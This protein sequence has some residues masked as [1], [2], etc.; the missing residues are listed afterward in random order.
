MTGRRGAA[1]SCPNDAELARLL[2]RVAGGDRAAFEALYVASAPKLF[3]LILRMSRTRPGAE[4]ILQEVFVKVWRGAHA[5]SPD[6]GAPMTW[7]ASIARNRTID[8]L[9]QRAPAAHGH[10]DEDE[11]WV[12]R[13]PDPLDLEDALMNAAD[14]RH[15]LARLDP[16]HRDCVL[17][18]YRDGFS[19][20]ELAERFERPVNTVKTWLHRAL[21]SL[22]ACLEGAP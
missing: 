13:I 21:A 12:A 5:Y 4:D 17:L 14:L 7:L 16:V 3:G 22:K 2:G 11:D 20:E 6:A 18:A 8:V 9:R 10:G 19:R 1:A 15:C